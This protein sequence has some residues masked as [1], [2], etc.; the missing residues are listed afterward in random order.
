MGA[1]PARHIT[2]LADRKNVLT[3][4]LDSNQH[5]IDILFHLVNLVDT[6]TFNADLLETLSHQVTEL[7]GG[8]VEIRKALESF[9][10][11]STD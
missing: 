11:S 9:T 10:D 7:K 5:D 3:S 4:L 1:E 6:D 8:F 2:A